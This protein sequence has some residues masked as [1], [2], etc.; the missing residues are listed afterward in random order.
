[1]ALQVNVKLIVC[2]YNIDS[3]IQEYNTLNQIKKNQE[4]CIHTV[5]ISFYLSAVHLV[6]S[7]PNSM[8]GVVAYISK[9]VI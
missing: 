2:K 7:H 5:S 9:L 1:M 6:M 8:G 4:V 3:F